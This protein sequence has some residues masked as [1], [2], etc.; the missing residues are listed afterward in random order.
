MEINFYPTIENIYLHFEVFI[1]RGVAT[2]EMTNR[3]QNN[4]RRIIVNERFNIWT[5]KGFKKYIL[6]LLL[7]KKKSTRRLVPFDHQAPTLH[8]FF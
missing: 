8:Q 2:V 3:L 6:M 5:R 7:A 1:L 4:P